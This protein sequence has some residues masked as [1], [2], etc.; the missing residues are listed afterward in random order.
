MYSYK[1]GLTWPTVLHS[2]TLTERKMALDVKFKK[3]S[4]YGNRLRVRGRMPAEKRR[5]NELGF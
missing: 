3:R 5:Y 1:N 4:S 2:T